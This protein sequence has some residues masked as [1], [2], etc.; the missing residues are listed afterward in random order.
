MR[1]TRRAFVTHAALGSL[2]LAQATADA[3]QVK[4][5]QI[6]P[7]AFSLYGTRTLT[8]DAA[9]DACAKIGYDAV[10]L[11]LMPGYPAE[12]K[13]LGKDERR[14]LRDRLRQHRSPRLMENLPLHGNE[15]T[16][17]DHLTRLQTARTRAELA[18]MPPILETILGGAVNDG[19]A[20]Q[21]A[22]RLT[23]PVA[24]NTKRSSL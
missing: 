3:A 24:E 21:F 19:S 23:G 8:L 2:A 16:H 17:K 7:F 13:R 6:M 14:R 22:D 18:L 1:I 4:T 12:P 5:P 20:R 10:E 9:L 11:A 15:Q